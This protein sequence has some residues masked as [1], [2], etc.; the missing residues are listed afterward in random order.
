[1]SNILKS[2]LL[3]IKETFLCLPWLILIKIKRHFKYVFNII[4]FLPFGN[5]KNANKNE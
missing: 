5:K 3:E 2:L 1:M 4:H